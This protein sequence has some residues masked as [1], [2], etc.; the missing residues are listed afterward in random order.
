MA[1]C[2]CCTVVSER[3]GDSSVGGTV[4]LLEFQVRQRRYK[5]FHGLGKVQRCE[6]QAQSQP[7]EKV[8]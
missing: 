4:W 2:D 8:F 6:E 3:K 1:A 7:C 5:W